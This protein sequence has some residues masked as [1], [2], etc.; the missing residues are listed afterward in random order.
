MLS[1][2]RVVDEFVEDDQRARAQPRLEELEDG[3]RVGL[4]ACHV[5]GVLPT[6]CLT[7]ASALELKEP[8]AKWWR[9]T[10]PMQSAVPRSSMG[11]IARATDRSDRS[12]AARPARA[13]RTEIEHMFCKVK[14]ELWYVYTVGSF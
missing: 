4:S 2:R 1:I 12:W 9:S 3:A 11:C 5:H 6:R 7:H 14:G 10:L 13:P 8:Q